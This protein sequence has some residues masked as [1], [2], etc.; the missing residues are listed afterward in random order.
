MDT[1]FN[2]SLDYAKSLDKNDPLASFRSR[3]YLLEDSIYLDGNSLGLMSKDSESH[4][5]KVIYEWKTM[6]INGWFNGSPPWFHYGEELGALAAPLVGAEP[7]E[8]V[9]TG[10]TTINLHSLVSTFYNPNGNC[11]KILADE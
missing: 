11:K 7:D 8:V 10:T 5:L 3:F 9:A 1:E 2:L 4:L 6:G